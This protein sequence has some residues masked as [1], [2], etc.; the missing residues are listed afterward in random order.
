MNQRPRTASMRCGGEVQVNAAG[1]A[2]L[3]ATEVDVF[4]LQV[5]VDAV[6]GAFAADA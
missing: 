5:V 3:D 6:F 2:C 4:D 1:R